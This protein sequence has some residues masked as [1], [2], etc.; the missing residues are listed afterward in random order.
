MSDITG[1]PSALPL[2]M[3]TIPALGSSSSPALA[4]SST[5]ALG[6]STMPAVSNGTMAANA[7]GS[8]AAVQQAL[9]QHLVVPS[10][11]TIS[12][13]S[14]VPI[15]LEMQSSNYSRWAFFFKSMCGKFR[16]RHHIDGS[17][18]PSPQDPVWDQA[19]CCV[20][21]WIFGTV[22]DAVLSLAVEG[23][24]LTARDIWVA[25]EGLFRA[26]QAPRAIFHLHE[27]HSMTQGDDTI[28]AYAERMRKKVADLRDVG[29]AV[30][31]PQLVLNLL[32]G[33]NKSFSGT[34]DDIA[35][36]AVLPDFSAALD[37]LRLKEL[38][39]ANEAKTTAASA[40][41]AASSSCSSPGCCSTSSSSAPTA[42]AG[43]AGGSG[44]GKGGGGQ[45]GGG[46]KGKKPWREAAPQ[47]HF[48]PA[49]PWVCF[50]PYG[51]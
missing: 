39:L 25:I 3:P 40:M 41:L 47:Q 46:K 26:N 17:A 16:L 31:E 45:G 29:H 10:Y 19:D 4:A 13:K 11:A 24:N 14:H 27:F 21:S 42:P 38:R 15:Q 1:D 49:G 28:D 33:V 37:M 48:R 30:P 51:P 5:P 6:A 34:A 9:A 12:V 7:A 18:P 43:G 50:N 32:R 2:G 22:D 20:R 36:A 35:N 8:M 44:Y 23:D